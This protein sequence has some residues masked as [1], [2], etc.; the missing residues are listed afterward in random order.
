MSPATDL[1]RR[2]Q[3]AAR[4]QPAVVDL[5]LVAEAP[6]S[7]PDRY[8]Y[9]VDVREHDSLFRYVCRVILGEEPTRQGKHA[10]LE[11]LKRRGVFLIDLKQTPVDTSPL[12]DYVPALIDRCRELSPRRIVLIKATV[13]DAAYR[14]L[15]AAGLPVVD[16]RVP[17]PGSGRQRQFLEAFG[18]AVN[19]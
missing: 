2:Q 16:I 1:V 10:L 12:S 14:A 18:R 4:Y 5:L 7:S 13:F 6:P 9:F 8:F 19:A 11:E 3:A 17:F 15:A